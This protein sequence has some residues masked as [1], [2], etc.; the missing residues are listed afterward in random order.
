[1]TRWGEFDDLYHISDLDRTQIPEPEA[2]VSQGGKYQT[3]I[4]GETSFL[5]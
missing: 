2:T 3:L 4:N 5:M 1:M